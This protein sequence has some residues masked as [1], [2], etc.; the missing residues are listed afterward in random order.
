M[1]LNIPNLLKNTPHKATKLCALLVLLCSLL[2]V[3]IAKRKLIAGGNQPHSFVN[4]LGMKMIR[5]PA[6]KFLMGD[7]NPPEQLK[8]EAFLFPDDE[9][10][11]PAHEVTI[12]HPF[13]ISQTEVTAAEFQKFDPQYKPHSRYAPYATGISWGKAVKFTQWLSQ[14]EGKPYR[15]P[16]EA[17]W[18]YGCRAGSTTPFSS[19]DHPLPEGQPNAWGIMNMESGPLEWVLDW[20]GRYKRQAQV[21]PVGPDWGFARVVRGGSLTPIGPHSKAGVPPSF[22]RRCANRASIAPVY[23]G[24]TPVGF[25]VVEAPMP[26]T[27]PYAAHIPF[28]RRFVIPASKLPVT[29]GPSPNKP[30]FQQRYLLPIPPENSSPQAIMAAGF[31]PAIQGHN[32]SPGLAVCPNGDVL[33][34]FFSSSP[35]SESLPNTAFIGTRLRFG[36]NQWDPP[37]VFMKFAD[38]NNQSAMLWND[39]GNVYFFGGGRGLPGIPFRWTTSRDNGVNWTPVQF[40][41]LIGPIGGYT[42]QP[43]TSAFRKDGTLYVATDGKGRQSVL[44]ASRNNGKTWFD[45]GGRTDGRHTAYV[46]LKDGCILG[47]GGKQTNIDG[48][49]PE[50]ISCDDGK[51]WQVR[52]SPFPALGSNQRPT[53]L[54]LADGDLFFASDFQNHFGGAP[55]AVKQRGAFVA[56]SKNDGKTWIVK[57][58]V[59][60]LPHEMAVLPERPGWHVTDYTNAATLGYAIAAQAP[61]G[62]IYLISTMNHPAQEFEMNEAWILSKDQ[63]RTPAVVGKGKLIP[64]RLTYPNG[65][66]K[67]TW[68]GKIEPDGRYEMNGVEE[69]YYAD[70]AKEYRVD[71]RNGLKIG[72]ETYW[73]KDGHKI[74]QWNHQADGLSTWTHYWPDGRKKQ[75]SQWQNGV[76]FG[77]ATLWSPSGKVIYH[78]QFRK[79]FLI[80]KA[81]D[82]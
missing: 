65:H 15:L 57:K 64:G 76:G 28:F 73:A 45:R 16:T 17:E 62:V 2:V 74:W 66:L 24:N 44:W 1:S 48:Y 39:R 58:L 49:M 41:K 50:S 31:S 70:G 68:T 18:E 5:V 81:Q 32:H 80:R 69:W 11:R 40:P 21:N 3:G 12:P 20:Y 22:Y 25:R 59:T 46:V 26:K 37:G 82:K 61:N 14:K 77:F 60:A 6:G 35:V 47:M 34:I 75:E 38:V 43:I 63:G 42:A 13:Y 51:T 72:L 30:W 27:K 71:Y 7:P 33:A 56:I 10:E 55:P 36:T 8:S 9:D 53:I 78:H 29:D 79:G 52:K 19:G 23:H 4:S 67:A 54:R